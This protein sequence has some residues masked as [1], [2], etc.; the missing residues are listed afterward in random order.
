MFRNVHSGNPPPCG[1]LRFQPRAGSAF[2]GKNSGPMSTLCIVLFLRIICGSVSAESNLTYGEAKSRTLKFLQEVSEST[3]LSANFGPDLSALKVVVENWP[4]PTASVPPPDNVNQ[5]VLLETVYRYFGGRSGFDLDLVAVGFQAPVYDAIPFLDG[6]YV[7]TFNDLTLLKKGMEARQ[8]YASALLKYF[9]SERKLQPE[10]AGQIVASLSEVFT[11]LSARPVINEIKV[12]T[13]LAMLG[14]ANVSKKAILLFRKNHNLKLRG[15][16]ED[17]S[18]SLY[19]QFD[20]AAQNWVRLASNRRPELFSSLYIEWLETVIAQLNDAKILG[21]L[22][23]EAGGTVEFVRQA[24]NLQSR[25]RRI[26]LGGSA[27]GDQSSPVEK[28]AAAFAL[29]LGDL[30]DSFLSNLGLTNLHSKNISMEK[31]TSIFNKVSGQPEI[32]DD[33]EVRNRFSK[34]EKSLDATAALAIANE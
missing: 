25:I 10:D 9:S 33:P 20:E 26:V 5:A 18:D 21:R 2:L 27:V 31:I 12:P 8:A 23:G 7:P 4:D 22:I 17:I 13:A 34:I 15:V 11:W 14:C 3:H 28:Q 16:K 19:T 32:F 6:N 29:S 30:D 1:I 24:K